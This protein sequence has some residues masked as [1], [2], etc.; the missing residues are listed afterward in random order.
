MC[1]CGRSKKKWQRVCE[2]CFIN[3]K[4]LPPPTE[5]EQSL[6][7]KKSGGS[8]YSGPERKC[9]FCQQLFKPKQNSQK[10][11]SLKHQKKHRD[12]TKPSVVSANRKPTEETRD[13]TA[14][15][16]KNRRQ[17]SAA[18]A[19]EAKLNVRCPCGKCDSDPDVLLFHHRIPSEKCFSIA[20]AVKSG[21]SESRLRA[22]MSKC[23]IICS[24]YHIKLHKL[25]SRLEEKEFIPSALLD[26]RYKAMM[27]SIEKFRQ[28]F[29][30]KKRKLT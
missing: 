12:E 9:P 11:C 29:G 18:I 5:E 20:W 6:V 10:F 3:G 23:D 24:N 8:Y 15:A 7:L 27:S 14:R 16:N 13:R 25:A 19:Y 4:T 22:E 17:A 21:I 1:R 26:P 2:G 30:T 28:R